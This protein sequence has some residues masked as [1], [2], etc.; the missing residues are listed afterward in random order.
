MNA[1]E[2]R[3]TLARKIKAFRGRKNWSQ[4]DL[5]EKS[6]LSIVYLS[7][8]ERGNKWPYLDTLVKLAEA[9]KV[10]VYELLKPE[11]PIPL[12]S[13]DI[14]AKFTEDAVAV[15]EKSL[16]TAGKQASRSLIAMRNQYVRNKGII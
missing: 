13:A 4:A 15:L 1:T 9:F 8:I 5:A 10:E 3:A 14:L 16:E 7:D 12:V 2:V 6:G 11:D